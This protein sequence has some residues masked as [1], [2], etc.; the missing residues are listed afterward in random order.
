MKPA[1]PPVPNVK[2]LR[3]GFNLRAGAIFAALWLSFA[4]NLY[5]VFLQPVG[6]LSLR[7]LALAGG[8]GLAASIACVLLA[9]WR[10]LDLLAAFNQPERRGWIWRAGL[11]ASAAVHLV[12]PAPPAQLFAPPVSLRLEFLPLGEQPARVTLVSLNNGMVD[13]SYSDVRLAESAQIQPGSGIVFDL[14]TG[15]PA[16]L[17]WQGRAWREIRW[18]VASDQPVEMVFI[19]GGRSERIR[20]DSGQPLEKQLAMAV[21]GSLYYLLVKAATLLAAALSLGGLIALLRQTP[22]WEEG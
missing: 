8:L 5:L 15:S 4:L 20:L 3:T 2:P 6:V 16:W 14:A 19:N 18:V 10:G 17:E 7:R 21:G 1:S 11:L 13:I 12:F 9:H 22:L